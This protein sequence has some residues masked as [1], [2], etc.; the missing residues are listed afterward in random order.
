MSTATV[1]KRNLD[2]LRS[3]V[4]IAADDSGEAPVDTTF[5]V[6]DGL[7][8]LIGGDWATFHDLEGPAR[9]SRHLQTSDGLEYVTEGMFEVAQDTD[10]PFWTHYPSSLCSLPDRVDEPLVIRDSEIFTRTELGRDPMH[11]EAFPEVRDEILVSWPYEPGV[12]LRLLI[13]RMEGKP[14][15]DQDCFLLRLLQPHLEPLL[16]HTVGSNVQPAEQPLTDRQL[17]ILGLVRE[18]MT[19]HQVGRHLG[20]SDGT[21]RK[22][23]E[24]S[25][26]RL[27]VQSRMAAVSSAFGDGGSSRQ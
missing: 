25:Y 23:L 14:F 22:H 21:V 20:I 7:R 9:R 2:W 26:G 16:R 27:N 12:N 8:E 4:D 13:T 6:L 3:I 17:E 15:S 5:A 10:D 18:G 24:N 1:T 11:M 19:N